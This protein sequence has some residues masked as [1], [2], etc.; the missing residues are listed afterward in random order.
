MWLE[1]RFLDSEVDGS[2]A[3]SIC[4]VLDQDILSVLL[5]STQL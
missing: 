5:H 4:C 2:N 1:C 3:A